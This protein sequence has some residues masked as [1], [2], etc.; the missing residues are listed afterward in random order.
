MSETPIQ[1]ETHDFQVGYILVNGE[2][3]DDI[4][5]RLSELVEHLAKYGFR[6]AHIL[7]FDRIPTAIHYI[8]EREVEP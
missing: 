8:A 3:D 6:I 1:S 4:N 5:A 2:S 7:R